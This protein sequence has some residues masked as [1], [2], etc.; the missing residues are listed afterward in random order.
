[1]TS[2]KILVNIVIAPVDPSV[3][4]E[5]V[6][7]LYCKTDFDTGHFK[8]LVYYLVLSLMYLSLRV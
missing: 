5:K 1:M 3:I 4:E 7:R 2:D 6:I 8:R